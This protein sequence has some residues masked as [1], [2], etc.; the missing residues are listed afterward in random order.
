MTKSTS[1]NSYTFALGR[2]KSAIATVKLSSGKAESFVNGIAI[3]SY[4]PAV[5]HKIKYDRPFTVTDTLG[6]YSFSAKIIG[7]GKVGQLE[8]LT[9]AV[10][11]ALIKIDVNF[12]PAL[13]A[14]NLITVDSRVRE[15]R[16]VG[17]GGKAR[18][19][20]QSPKR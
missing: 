17:T 6:K 20:K 1:K 15:R 4:F 10:S 13:R 7:G 3:T 18:R 2:R 14:A 9:L 12:K 5:D 11:R 19:Q 16:M 8:A